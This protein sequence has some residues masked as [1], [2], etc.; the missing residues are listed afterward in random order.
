MATG[1]RFIVRVDEKLI[2]DCADRVY[3]YRRKTF[4]NEPSLVTDHRRLARWRF[5]RTP[6][7]PLLATTPT[8]STLGLIDI[9]GL[10]L[11]R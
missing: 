7:V 11:V 4:G 2:T 8:R 3:S 10:L 5:A 6:V 9:V 1:T